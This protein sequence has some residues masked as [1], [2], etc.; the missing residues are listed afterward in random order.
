MM[1]ERLLDPLKVESNKLEVEGLGLLPT[2][3]TFTSDKRTELVEGITLAFFEQQK[4]PIEGYE[5]HMGQTCFTTTGVR[6]PFEVRIMRKQE[7]ES[8]YHPDG[9]ISQNGKLWGTY[10]HGV[11]HN[12]DFRRSWLNQLRLA[13]GW[14]AVIGSLKFQQRREDAFDR[15]A[16]HVRKHLDMAKIYEMIPS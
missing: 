12:D 16:L 9:V 6:H 7:S 5:I 4:L 10:V 15:L 1:G 8:E 3:T 14:D 2:E 13:K 11:L